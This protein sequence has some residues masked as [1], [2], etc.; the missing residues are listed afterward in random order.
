MWQGRFG[1]V[2]MDEAHLINAVRY[3]SLNPVRARLVARGEDWPW[4]SVRAHLAGKD[5]GVVTVAPVLDRV[6]PFQAFL[7]QPFD[8]GANFEALRRAETIGRPV[9]SADWIAAVEQQLRRPIARRK[10]G[11]RA[12]RE[13]DA[14]SGDLLSKL[15]P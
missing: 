5:D 15:A 13:A 6:G 7:D 10:P 1:A 3:V 14:D 8:E 2:A 12:K 9:G 4:S 11:P